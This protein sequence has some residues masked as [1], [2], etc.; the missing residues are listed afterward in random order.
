M[1]KIARFGTIL[2]LFIGNIA[3]AQT[4]V[5][6]G[7][8]NSDFFN[9][10]NWKD[11][12]TNA[13]PAAGTINPGTIDPG[14]N[15][16][17]TLQIN[18]AAAVIT[19]SGSIQFGTGSLAVGLANL[20]ATS[21][22]G[23]NVTV[24]SGGYIDLSSPT[25]FQN[26]VQIN[27]TSGIG[28]VRTTNYKASAVSASNLG[29]IKV[30]GSASVYQTNL[31]LDHY[32]LN[33]CVIRANLAATTPLTVY[34]SANL[35]GTSAL[36]TVNTLHS[37]TAIAGTMNNKTESFLL[38]KGFMVTFANE[39]DGTGKSK[40]YIAS[41]ADLVINSLPKDLLNSVSF[42]RV[43]PW[44]WV[45]KKGRTDIETDLNTSWVYKWN[46]TLNTTLDWEYAPM[47][48]GWTGA[49]TDDVPIYTGKYNSTHVM[50][51][52]EPDNCTGQSG[53]Y[54]TGL[55]SLKLC[56]TDA[57]VFYHKNLM[58]TGMR[59][60]SPG[61]TE[62]ASRATGWLKEF[63]DKATI[64]D[65]R[66]DVIAVHWY[67]WGNNPTVNTNPTAAQVFSR[68]QNYITTIHNLYGLPIWITEFNA[69][70]ARSQ[71]INAGF[72]ALALPWLESLDYVERYNWFPYNTGTD[73]YT[74]VANTNIS[75]VGTTY[76]DQAST[77][78]VPEESVFLYNNLQNV[79][80]N[81]TATA[82]STY[83]TFTASKAV[84]G[85]TSTT[86][87]RWVKNFGAIG[88][89]NYSILPAWLEVNLLGSYTINS[90]R[91]IED[92]NASK[93]FGF[94]VWD[95][96]LN[97]GAGGWSSVLTVTN[98]P[99][100]PLTTYKTFTP[101]STTKV[102]LNITGHNDTGYIR[103]FELE[104][105]GEPNN[106]TWAGTTSSAWTV[107]T[108]W[109]TGIVPDKYSNVT[110]AGGAP[111][112]PT[113]STT[114]TVNS[115]NIAAGATLTV[116]APNF[117]V[118]AAI[119]NSG[120]MTLAN[121]SN[122]IQGGSI[123]ANTGNINVNRNSNA[124]K[125]LDY[126]MWSSPVANQNLLAF[127]PKTTTTRF[128]KYN[129]TTNVYNAVDP[130]ITS[131]ADGTGY[132]IRMPNTDP[133]VGYNAGTATLVYPGV[134]T[135]IP[136]NG[137]VK[138]SSLTSDRFY[139]IGNPYPSTIS[140]ASFLTGN[141]TGGTLYFWR[142]TNG[143]VN[144][145]SAY[146]VYTTLGATAAGAVAPNNIVPN[147]TIQVGQGFIVKTTGTSLTFTNAM[148][149]GN[150][151]TQFLKTKQVAEPDRIWLNLTNTTGVFSQTLVGY[152][153]GAT[154][155]FDNGIDGKSIN[156]AK[157]ALTSSINNE[158]YTIQGRPAPFDPSDI[159]ALNF[160]T[161]V[162][163][164]YTIALDH[165]DGVFA[166]G[167]DIYLADSK[168]GVETILKAAAYSF[169]AAAG[170]DNA[171]FS[172]KYQKTLKVDAPTF[173]E[174][175]VQVYKIN[176]SLYVNS[177]TIAISNISVFDIQGRLI[178]EQKNVKA[179]KASIKDL[180]ATNQ[181]LIVKITGEDNSEVSK[182]VVY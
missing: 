87:S 82:S 62:D 18:S 152:M 119:A 23:G 143:V 158:E 107:A 9:E 59:L 172:L 174:N 26:N 137:T 61:C 149:L 112:Q 130:S 142:K 145:N 163:G 176:G 134:F 170:V 148:R 135:G 5:W 94:E 122:L 33:G 128:Y 162:A 35:Q 154:L 27:F 157:V 63:Y 25:P 141:L 17:L 90:I 58:K 13:I 114:L 124:L 7:A 37:G 6:T 77:P 182:K 132:L 24:N 31:R 156:D 160:K 111:N 11:S 101:V 78:S 14:T 85:D 102:R 131:F 178:A 53:Q 86:A 140:A 4:I 2:L 91:I 51:F 47:A 92:I 144:S 10:A 181:V 125:Q 83:S 75:S 54:T 179:T 95:V 105:Y 99:S 147:G 93:D 22:S 168:T 151:S 103:M 73:F 79:A 138:L 15:I 98:N 129:G 60:V 38:K 49:E 84:D 120:A 104:V 116:T 113:I 44:N 40:N 42:I 52:N 165:F 21:L 74:D 70:P 106:P 153:E 66:I 81:K 69:N 1:N 12:V 8:A 136:N 57:A 55:N 16:N 67:D 96:T 30:N 39:T 161:D 121:N 88:D 177:G 155:G 28:W 133:T 50:S 76:R 29:Q 36:I 171:R 173:N 146:A 46:N 150:T 89:V 110:I 48:W 20:T 123:N 159:V 108:N 167:Q 45:T 32:Y 41:E 19:A 97:A 175:S 180:K 139:S 100:S 115:L 72:M 71:T 68:F 65:I 118:T 164:D 56:D 34:D 117:T 3:N 109:N 64:Q 169:T 126:T 166:N 80:L 127:S 43:M